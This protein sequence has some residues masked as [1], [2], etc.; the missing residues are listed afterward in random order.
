MGAY[1]D[2]WRRTDVDF[3]GPQRSL[4]TRRPQ[5][6]WNETNHALQGSVQGGYVK[7]AFGGREL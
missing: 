1:S 7:K 6:P 2:S 4:R 5:L 3:S